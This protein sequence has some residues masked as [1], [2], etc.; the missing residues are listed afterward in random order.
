[1]FLLR[2]FMRYEIDTKEHWEGSLLNVDE[3]AER[4]AAEAFGE[5][6]ERA[7]GLLGSIGYQLHEGY[8]YDSPGEGYASPDSKRPYENLRT[9]TNIAKSQR[10]PIEA[11]QT[12]DKILGWFLSIRSDP[13]MKQNPVEELAEWFEGYVSEMGKTPDMETISNAVMRRAFLSNEK[14]GVYLS[15][16]RMEAYLPRNPRTYGQARSAEKMA[17]DPSNQ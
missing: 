5:D 11:L 10:K 9:L 6:G 2:V 8:F 1:M 15:S 17:R 12:I 13:K 14:I 3:A 4:V 16:P 7:V